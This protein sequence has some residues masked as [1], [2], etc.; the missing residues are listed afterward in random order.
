MVVVGG[1]GGGSE[2]WSHACTPSARGGTYP[3]RPAD[4]G[5][6]LR[7][8]LDVLG[9]TLH[10]HRSAKGH[11]GVRDRHADTGA[12][13]LSRDKNHCEHGEEANDRPETHVALSLL[14]LSRR[15]GRE[16]IT[17]TFLSRISND[18]LGN[19]IR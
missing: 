18:H 2:R 17:F 7:L 8:G 15:R 9:A 14:S 3:G 5:G 13:V 10:A 19:V 12:L 6:G 1:G 11:G 4:V 16:K